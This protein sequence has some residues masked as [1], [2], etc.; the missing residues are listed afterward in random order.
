M[1]YPLIFLSFLSS[2]FGIQSDLV[3]DYL[4]KS[5]LAAHEISLEKRYPESFVNGIFKDNILLGIAYMEEKVHKKDEV[6]WEEV[7]K[8]FRYALRLKPSEVFAFHDDVLPEYMGKV[9]KT[10]NAHFIFEEG[11]KSDGYLAGDG[12]CHLASL[13]YWVA[14]DA[15]L[16]AIA[17]T[18]H[19]FREIPEIPREYGVSIY[20]NPE[21]RGTNAQQNLYIK[22]TLEKPVVFEFE[23]NGRILKISAVEEG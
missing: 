19:D 22:N 14:K 12:V 5:I 1:I 2:W 10:T 21:T 15:H 8:P 7:T 13:L 9:S 20:S 18:N 11:F 4:P 17:P 3:A 16:E 6:T 23:Y